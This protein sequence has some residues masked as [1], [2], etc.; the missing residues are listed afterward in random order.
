MP[1]Q[2]LSEW[3]A[4]AAAGTG[5]GVI[6]TTACS[7]L[8]VAKTRMQVQS[9]LGQRKYQGLVQS[10]RTIYFEEGAVGWYRG[11][12]PSLCSVCVFWS[13]YFPCYDLAKERIAAASG[14]SESSSLVHMGGAAASGLL[15]DVLTNPLWVVRTRLATQALVGA[16]QQYGTMRHAFATIYREEGLRAFFAGL[17]A[18]VLGLSHIM[19]QFPL[20]E[21]FKTELKRALGDGGADSESVAVFAVASGVS[22]LVASTFTYPHEVIRTRM[23]FDKGEALYSSTA[24]CIAKTVRADGLRGLWQGFRV[25]IVRT[26]PQCVIMFTLYEALSRRLVA[27][28][29]EQGAG[30]AADRQAPLHAAREGKNALV[31]QSSRGQAG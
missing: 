1:G 31:R 3:L 25:N 23:Q 30:G 9:A 27:L 18:S 20:Y 13:V 22:K 11:L 17:P 28:T 12:V 21:K 6:S 29:G 24:D 5:A 2:S 19:I 15:T 16:G 26:I 10:L 14:A 7:P 4:K 8:D